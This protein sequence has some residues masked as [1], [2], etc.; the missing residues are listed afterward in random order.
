MPKAK[1]RKRSVSR[2]PKRTPRPPAKRAAGIQTEQS[3]LPEETDV[4]KPSSTV[5][6]RSQGI[7]LSLMVVMLVMFL[8]IALLAP[9]PTSPHGK[10]GGGTVM[11]RLLFLLIPL[12]IMYGLLWWDKALKLIKR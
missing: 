5:H 6:P 2:K 12:G 4:K 8:A 7:V 9:D 3:A 11:W 10:P 1:S